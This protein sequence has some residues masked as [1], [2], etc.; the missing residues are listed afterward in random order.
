M[1]SN[2]NIA[3][4]Q[5]ESDKIIQTILNI[6]PRTASAGGGKTSDEIVLDFVEMMKESL[7][8]I[9]NKEEHHKEIFK[10]IN[11]GL[12]HSLSTVLLQEIERF[13]LLL[14][15][16]KVS[17]KLLKK[18][19]KGKI[20][21]SPELDLMYSAIIKNQLPPNWADVAYPSLKPLSSWVKDLGERVEFMRHWLLKGHPSSF[22]LSGFFFPHGFMTGTL[23]TYAR[24]HTKAVDKLAF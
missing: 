7:P 16:M 14:G 6:Q 8:P 22:W 11:K 10:P 13:N 2:A 12:L 19:I 20:I 18:A 17:L 4:Q 24:K 23:Q 21:M 5:Q 9:L 3:Y 15:K 1:H